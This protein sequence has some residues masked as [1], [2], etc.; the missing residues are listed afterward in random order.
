MDREH[1]KIITQDYTLQNLL[2]VIITMLIILKMHHIDN[3]LD[4]H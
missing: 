2:I 3:Q 1:H 4:F